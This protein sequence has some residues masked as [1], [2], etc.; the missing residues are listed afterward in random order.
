MKV[1]I[2][3]TAGTT[4]DFEV[5]PRE[6]APVKYEEGYEGAPLFGPA[7]D[8]QCMDWCEREGHA[9]RHRKRAALVVP[10]RFKAVEEKCDSVYRVMVFHAKRAKW[11]FVSDAAY[12]TGALFRDAPPRFCYRSDLGGSAKFDGMS[13]GKTQGEDGQAALCNLE[14]LRGVASGLWDLGFA[15]TFDRDGKHAV[16]DRGTQWV[17]LDE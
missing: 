7:S 12:C 13:S 10:D 5:R 8:L 14:W 16:F 1:D 3:P 15:L 6:G 11:T 4:A 2:I 17:T 9:Y